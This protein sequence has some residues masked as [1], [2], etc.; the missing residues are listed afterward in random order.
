MFLPF[1]PIAV[2]SPNIILGDNATFGTSTT[3]LTTGLV[4][5]IVAVLVMNYAY[6]TIHAWLYRVLVT[7]QLWTGTILL[8]IVLVGQIFSSPSFIPTVGL[9]PVCYCIRQPIQVVCTIQTVRLTLA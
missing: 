4:I 1:D 3:M 9:I 5:G 6:P 2:T 7:E 8:V